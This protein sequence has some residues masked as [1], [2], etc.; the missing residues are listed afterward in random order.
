M[1]CSIYSSSR[2]TRRWPLAVFY[3]MVSIA[4]VNAFVMFLSYRDSPLINRFE[5]IKTLG[6]E[7]IVPHLRRRLMVQTLPRSLKTTIKKVLMMDEEQQDNQERILSDKL[8]KRKT[9][10]KC[11]WEKRRE[12]AYKCSI[13]ICL[14]CSRRVCT[15]CVVDYVQ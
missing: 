8:E 2:T 3:R 14:E 11:P 10:S 5:F 13:P 4:S 12:T 7:T 9:C 15:L 6:R 1:K